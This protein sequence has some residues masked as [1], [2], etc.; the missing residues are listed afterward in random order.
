MKKLLLVSALICALVG[1]AFAASDPCKD[2]VAEAK[3]LAAKC[4]S[5]KKGSSEFKKCAS[6]YKVL[7]NQADQACRSGGLDEKGM[8]QAIAQWEKQ[9]N[10][11]KGKQNKRC[12]S[13]L[14]QLGHYQFQLEEKLFLDAQGQYEEDVAWCAD[15]DNKPA[16]CANI[17]QLPKAEHS[18]SL[19][20]FLEYID[21][22]PKEDKTPVVMYQAAAVLEASGEDDK[23]YRLRE[24]L[25]KGFPDNGLVPKAWLRMAEYHFMNRK[26]R[27]AINA[28]KKVTGFENLTGKEAALAMYHLAESYYNIAEYET[29][30]IKYYDYIIGADKGKYP[31]DLRAEAMDFMAASFSDLEGGGVQEAEAFLKDKKVPFKDSVYYR[32]GMKNKDHDRN[33]EA[34]QSFK[35]L[36]QINP[37]YID[38]PLADIA[39]VE[40][41]I[42]QQKFDEAQQHRYVVVKRYDRNSSWYKKNQKYPESVKNAERAIRSAML[43]I[44]QFHHARAAKLTKEGD[45][46]AGKKQYA[47]A[48]KAYEAFLKRYAKEPTWDEYK[49]HINLALVYQE[50]GQFA[51]AAKMFNWIVDTDT[52]RY[53]RRPMGSESLLKKEEAAYNAVL[54]MDQSRENA[55]KNK[56][57]DD[58]VKA[59][60]SEETKA[61][62]AQVDKYMKKFGQNKEAA[63]LAYNAAI[64]HY[65]AKQYKTAVTVLRELRQKYPNHQYILLIS[66]MLA[67]SLLESNQLD[68]SLKE[69]EWLYKQYHDFNATRNDSMAKEI[70]KAIAA[71]LFQMAEQSVKNGQYEKGAQAYLALVKRYPLVSFS[72]K[73]VFE[74]GAAYENAKQYTKAAETF[75]ILPKQYSSSPL[76]IKGVLRAASAYKKDNKPREA[77]TTFLFIT[78]QF[79]Q[80]SMAFQAIG[81]AAQTYDSIPDKKQAAITFELAYKRYPKNEKTPAFLYSAC[82]SY[83]EAKMTDEAIRC[84][85]DLVRDYPKSTYALDAAFSI[86]LAY[87]NAKKWD[88]AAKEYHNF[89]R[90]YTEDKEKLIAA[91]IGAAR[92]YMELKEEDKAVEDYRKTL[93]A[94]DKYGLQIKNAD[95]GIPA[96]AAFYLGEHEFHKMDPYVLKGKEKDKAKTIKTLVE[97]LQKAMGHYSK[98]AAYASEKWTFR[99]TNKMGMLFVTMAAKIREQELNGKKEEERFAERITVV[100][101]LPTYYEQA[102]PIFQKNIDL[103]RDQGFYNQD[104]IEAEEGYIEM[105]YQGCAVFV[106]VAD[107]FANSPLP[108]SAAIVKEYVEYEGAVKEDAIEM[109]HEDLEAY[110]EALNEKSEGAKQLAIPQCA[111]GIKASAH[112]GIDN[113]WTAKLF[114]TL[115][116]LDETNEANNTKIEKFDPSTLFSDP[117]Y[118]KTKARL[119][120]IAKS[121]VMTPEE[122]LNT[123]RD[124]IKDAKAENEKLK[125]ELASL[126]KQLAPAPA[127]AASPAGY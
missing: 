105:Y 84:S 42:V 85:K 114:E 18:K 46:E 54:M 121:E 83:D 37:D 58:A 117:S 74:A 16:K 55:K 112:Y 69:F 34:V 3:K 49:V 15:R 9:V 5:Y 124:I 63:E 118:F 65:D 72:D 48:I 59:Y 44:P 89:I 106:E 8:R 92:A 33:E 99:A 88:E 77:A 104:V 82:L 47:E 40:I 17:D 87:A 126:K 78:N 21:K 123:Y 75:M 91:Y 76:T 67:Q 6:S 120:Q 22:Y 31:N 98:S 68:E 51:N 32:I 81:F 14:Q 127:P 53:G 43:D 26:F 27:D 109:A 79:P 90:M 57:G 115:K 36:M 39:M 111:T 96:E 28:Y 116:T 38:A 30:A 100:Q 66:R 122:Q 12:A 94:Y 113:Q 10:N 73:A 95:P 71:V 45:L 86:P 103:A 13:A 102:R 20:Y 125:A 19:G 7:K 62:F 97:I 70:E 110:R 61:Y 41:F 108:D 80:D 1:N 60:K 11:C 50:M 35:R 119:E 2:K 24:R 23:A 56:Y 25:V 4:K 93:E 107:A 64:V 101:Q 52:T 29:A